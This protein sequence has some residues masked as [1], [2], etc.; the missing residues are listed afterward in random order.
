MAIHVP[1]TYLIGWTKINKYYYGVRYAK[2][3]SPEDLWTSY[4]TSSKLVEDMRQL[5]GEPDVVR[6]RRVFDCR[7]KAVLWEA[8]VLSR[9]RVLKESKWLNQNVQGMVV[10]ETQSKEHIRK[11]TVNKNHNPRQKEIA[12]QALQKAVAV[13]TGKKQTIETQNKKRETYFKN[14]SKNKH[15]AK[16]D[17]WTKYLIEGKVYKGNKA[18]MET[19]GI[20]EPTIYNRVKNPRFDWVRLH[21]V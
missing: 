16:R 10:I 21:G 4:F 9:M 8:K 11:R 19:F 5:Y 12:L 6:V 3:C 18:I 20:T 15:S 13:N 2:G 7:E 1:Y 17:S 14:W